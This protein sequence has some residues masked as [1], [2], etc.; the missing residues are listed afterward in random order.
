[1]TFLSGP[2]LHLAHTAGVLILP[3]HCRLDPE[4]GTVELLG[5]IPFID[6]Y[7]NM[8]TDSKYG[9]T[10][11]DITNDTIDAEI[12]IK[13][14]SLKKTNIPKKRMKTNQTEY[15]TSISDM[16]TETCT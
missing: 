6:T 14:S 1:M 9:E 13:R 5:R 3:Y 2:L 16:T 11:T 8:G 15:S 4:E 10:K 12:N 7:A